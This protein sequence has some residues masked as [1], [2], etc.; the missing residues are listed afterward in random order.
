MITCD[1]KEEVQMLK[2]VTD[3]AVKAGAFGNVQSVV[4]FV[5]LIKLKEEPCPTPTTAA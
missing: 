5:N 3:A 4:T 2:A 1:T